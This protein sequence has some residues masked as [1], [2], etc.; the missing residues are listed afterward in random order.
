[1]LV[2]HTTGSVFRILDFKTKSELLSAKEEVIDDQRFVF[3]RRIFL[4]KDGHEVCV[5]FVKFKIGFFGCV[6]VHL[7]FGHLRSLLTVFA[8]LVFL[9]SVVKRVP[10]VICQ[11]FW[12]AKLTGKHVLSA[13]D[14][15][16]MGLVDSAF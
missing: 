2:I 1:M 15:Q 10:I 7:V 9:A 11:I 3:E 6:K 14:F 5:G 13:H 8:V 4:L 12:F 16:T